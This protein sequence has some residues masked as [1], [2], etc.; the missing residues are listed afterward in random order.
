MSLTNQDAIFTATLANRI[1]DFIAKYVKVDQSGFIVRRQ[2]A[3][4]SR[5]VLSAIDVIGKQ[6]LK[7]V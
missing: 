7:A 5:S 6:N 2:M 1:N 4:L 3:D